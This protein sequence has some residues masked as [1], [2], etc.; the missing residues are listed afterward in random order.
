[1][2]SINQYFNIEIF[3]TGWYSGLGGRVTN[4]IIRKGIRQ[5]RFREE[6]A[7]GLIECDWQDPYILEIPDRTIGRAAFI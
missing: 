7:S 6:E 5:P 1:M 2:T 3:R 4:P